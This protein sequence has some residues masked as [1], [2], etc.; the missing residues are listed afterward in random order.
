M[1]SDPNTRKS[2]AV[3]EDTSA[4]EKILAFGYRHKTSLVLAAILGAA[5]GYASSYCFE[6]LYQADAVLIPSDEM[7]GIAQNSA[8]GGLG[9]LA[10]LVGVNVAGGNKQNEAVAT[11]RS[12]GLT[13]AYIDS[14]HL[15]PILFPNRWDTVGQRWK[16]SA[17]VPT[18]EDGFRVFDKSIRGVIENRKS[19]LIVISVTWRD[20][21]LAKQWTDGLIEGANDLL[22]KQAIERSA[23][24]LEYL[25]KASDTT[26]IM[27]VKTTIYKI[28]ES[29]I[30]KQM[31]AT[32]DK[33]YAFRV[34]D[35][36]VV[37]ERKVFPRRSFFLVYG[38]LLAPI[39]W[40][41]IVWLRSKK[42]V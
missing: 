23:H 37:P 28:M 11:L 1:I 39:L 6:P 7:L 2:N 13:S 4:F 16:A 20:P 24:N 41:A 27:E 19:G 33:N 22:R 25:Q 18:I 31:I 15:L 10:S 17:R 36:A 30:K 40:A 5:S 32:G 26:S 29:E 12:R 42:R 34:V 9:G 21:T 8:L 14:N 3:L 38:V 35:P